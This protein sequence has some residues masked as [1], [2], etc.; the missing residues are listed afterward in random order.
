MDIVY[1]CLFYHFR[2]VSTRLEISHKAFV[3]LFTIFFFLG[4]PD[5]NRKIRQKVALPTKPK[6]VEEAKN[7]HPSFPRVKTFFLAFC[8]FLFSLDI[9]QHTVV[10]TVAIK[11]NFLD[12]RVRI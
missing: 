3:A 4:A 6:K 12:T 8:L 7:D 10:A 9:N 11:L 1:V 5:V 2:W